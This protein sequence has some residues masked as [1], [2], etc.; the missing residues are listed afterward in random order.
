VPA[1]LQ[2]AGQRFGRL[3]VLSDAGNDGH[4]QSRWRCL[5]DCGR[6]AIVKAA[7]LR[8]GDT[9]SCGCAH[10]D[11][12]AA[13]NRGKKLGPSGHRA[14]LSGLR[15]GRWTVLGYHHTTADGKGAWL[16]RCDC[17]TKRP[18]VGRDVRS[19][20]S[21]SC[22]CLNIEETGR[23]SR[24]HGLSKTREY[25]IWGA[26]ISR[27]YNPNVP[28]YGCYGGRGIRVCRRW[29]E[30]FEAFLADVGACPAGMS[31]EREDVNGDYCP[32]NCRWATRLQQ[33]QNRRN[34]I[35]LTL[36]GNT[37]CLAEWGRRLGLGKSAL[38]SRLR[39][40]LTES[41]RSGDRTAYASFVRYVATAPGLSCYWCGR[42]VPIGKRHVDHI[43]P[44]VKGGAD[45]VGNVCCSC[46]SCNHRKWATMPEDF[47]GQYELFTVLR[48]SDGLPSAPARSLLGPCRRRRGRQGPA[49]LP[50]P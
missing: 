11:R 9:R 34:N 28:H 39:K 24:T 44:I 14:D 36:D 46:E 41:A 27:C 32:Q 7:Y 48:P 6:E 33:S 25:R 4:G 22:G 2:L 30:S 1:R 23:R 37:H 49:A 38:Y 5:C 13:L 21:R 19:G 16:C 3:V 45:D 47:A 8:T 26:M 20:K 17:G 50:R 12:A 31:I 40:V 29:R 35:M 42:T 15:F 43:I 10:L 18:V